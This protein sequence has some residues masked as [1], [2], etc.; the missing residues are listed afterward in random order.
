MKIHEYIHFTDYI[1]TISAEDVNLKSNMEPKNSYVCTV[2]LISNYHLCKYILTY[3]ALFRNKR[4]NEIVQ[5][6]TSK[7]IILVLEYKT[8]EYLLLFFIFSNIGFYI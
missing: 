5:R 7:S 1:Y 2:Y 8:S 6:S 4:F 3:L